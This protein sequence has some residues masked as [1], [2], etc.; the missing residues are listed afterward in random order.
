MLP[1]LVLLLGLASYAAVR[2]Q[3]WRSLTIELFRE[4]GVTL[5]TAAPDRTTM[6]RTL[7]QID[8]DVL[9]IV[10]GEEP[11]ADLLV[12]HRERVDRWYEENRTV[13]RQSIGSLRTL[14]AG[15][16]LGGSAAS[17]WSTFQSVGGSVGAAAGVG[18]AAV[19]LPILRAGLG[20]LASWFVRQRVK[21]WLGP[22]AIG[23]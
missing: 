14:M 5:D 16:S 23:R 13:V 17:G 3:A 4:G 7:I 19:L 1:L 12:Q 21:G 10:G 9:V 15:M 20:W 18:L 2:W 8:G 11:T 22:A 6:L